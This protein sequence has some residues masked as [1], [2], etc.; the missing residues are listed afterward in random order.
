MTA[1]MPSNEPDELDTAAISAAYERRAAAVCGE[2]LPFAMRM[3]SRVDP[4]RW[5]LEWHLPWWLGNAFGLDPRIS[6]EFVVTNVLGLASLRL[7]DD[8]VDGDVD[9]RD[10][11]SAPAMRAAL[12]D[13]SVAPYHSRF[14]AASPFWEQLALRM[15]EWKGAIEDNGQ[16]QRGGRH[17]VGVADQDDLYRHLAVRGAPLKISAFAVCLLTQRSATFAVVERCLDHALTAMVLYDHVCDWDEDLAAGRWNAFVAASGT[18]QRAE[19]RQRSRSTMLATMMAGN[20]IS[21][22]FARIHAELE[23]AVVASDQAGVP[24]LSTHLNVLA[25]RLDKEATVLQAHYSELGEQAAALVFGNHRPAGRGVL[26]GA[27]S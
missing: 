13:A 19:D 20:A 4:E 26:P 12:Y 18:S 22:S 1:P 5:S 16:P 15:A 10:R 6:T 8:L 3:L 2:Q 9:P 17:V 11:S 14:P 27:T 7:Q 24:P 25:A 21:D 23:R